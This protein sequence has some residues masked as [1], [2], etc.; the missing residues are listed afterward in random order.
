MKYT[1]FSNQNAVGEFERFDDMWVY[2][3]KARTRRRIP[4]VDEEMILSV[5][6]NETGKKQTVISYI[7]K[8]EIRTLVD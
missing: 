3:E 1:L 4:I 8:E 7:T 2:V 6:N 5:Q